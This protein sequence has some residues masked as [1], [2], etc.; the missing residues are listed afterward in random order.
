MAKKYE[1]PCLISLDEND[2]T[3]GV[4]QPGTGPTT[5]N[6]CGTGNNAAGWGQSGA[7]S[8]GISANGIAPS[9]QSGETAQQSC[10]SGI[11]AK[12]LCST[13]TGVK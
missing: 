7:C 4:C 12:G 11:S 9:C 10:G 3:I 2:M 8:Y 1:K 13:G 6:R 5:E